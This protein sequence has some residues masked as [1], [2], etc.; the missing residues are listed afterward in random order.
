V[1]SAAVGS[2]VS[3]AEGVKHY[4]ESQHG[5]LPRRTTW[6]WLRE[7]VVNWYALGWAVLIALGVYVA[8]SVAS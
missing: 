2:I 8:I 6:G 4:R 3:A 7:Y 5:E 1:A